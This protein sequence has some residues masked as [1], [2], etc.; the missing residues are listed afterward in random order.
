MEKLTE[1]EQNF[2]KSAE[3]F[4]RVNLPHGKSETACT[5][6]AGF[7]DIVKRLTSATGPLSEQEDD[8]TLRKEIEELLNRHS[9]ENVCD[10]PDFIL[11]HYLDDCLRAYQTATLQREDWYGRKK[12]PA[13]LDG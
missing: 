4:L 10:T 11:A 6:I 8:L 3:E 7:L 2:I 5:Y 9:M 13:V 1:Y 12:E